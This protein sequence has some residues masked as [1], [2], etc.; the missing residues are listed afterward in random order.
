MC[1]VV[2]C[3]NL[4]HDITRAH[5]R[6]AGKI[7]RRPLCADHYYDRLADSKG[8]TRSEWGN[9]FHKHRKYM[10]KYCENIDGRLGFKCTTTIKLGCGMLQGDHKNGVPFDDVPENIQTL[11]SC[12][13][14]YKSHVFKDYATVGRKAAKLL[15]AEE[16]AKIIVEA[17][18]RYA[19]A[20][21]DFTSSNNIVVATKSDNN[22]EEFISSSKKARKHYNK[23][24]KYVASHDDATVKVIKW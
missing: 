15:N 11:C 8:M 10:K 13:H 19:K 6:L 21:A 23:F 18:I 17:N 4:G 12:C 20:F 16:K 7:Q 1:K 22:I 5:F 9:S 24:M 14:S 2:G 3:E